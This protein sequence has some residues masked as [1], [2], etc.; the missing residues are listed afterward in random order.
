MKMDRKKI[1]AAVIVSIVGCLALIVMTLVS[2]FLHHLVV[3]GS[4]PL[5]LD[6][7]AKG[8][9]VIAMPFG[10]LGG[11]AF[12]YG[13]FLPLGGRFVYRNFFIQYEAH[14]Q[15]CAQ[16]PLWRFLLNADTNGNLKEL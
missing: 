5:E 8:I 14:K 11:I 6:A 15:R 12:I 2:V 16:S 4:L 1:K 13:V 7:F 9:G 3:R 10:F